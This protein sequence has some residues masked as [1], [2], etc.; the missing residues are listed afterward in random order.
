[1]AGTLARAGGGRSTVAISGTVPVAA[2]DAAPP[3]PLTVRALVLLLLARAPPLGAT[4]LGTAARWTARPSCRSEKAALDQADQKLDS[5]LRGLRGL[6]ARTARSATGPQA[7][8]AWRR[9]GRVRV[10][11]RVERPRRRDPRGADGRRALHRARGRRERAGRGLGAGRRGARGWRRSTGCGRSAPPSAVR[12]RRRSPARATSRRARTRCAPLG[13][14][15]SGRARRR[16]LRRRRRSRASHP[17]GELPATV[18]G[19]R[20]DARRQRGRRHRHA[21]DRARPRAR[22]DAAV[23]ER[24]RQPARASSRRSTCLTAAGAERDRRRPAASSASR[25]SRTGRSPQAVRAAV[26]R[27][28]SYHTAAGNSATSCTTRAMFRQSPQSKFHDFNTGGGVDNT[29]GVS[30]PPGGSLLCVLQWDDPFGRA[31]DDYDLLLLDENRDG[32]RRQQR[33][34]ERPRRS[35]SRSWTRTT[36]GAS[37]EVAYA[38]HRAR[39]AAMRA[40]SSCSALRDVQSMEHVTPGVEHLRPR[41]HPRGGHGRRHRR[42]RAWPRHG[43]ALQLAGARAASRSRRRSRPKPDLA[44]VRRR[45]HEVRASR[46]SSAR[47]RPRRTWPPSRR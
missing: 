32:D 40:R 1:M 4:S 2:S 37:T 46:R 22:R 28:V 3:L 17:T 42:R 31:S 33:R 21:R 36:T 38:R 34:A 35:A 25:T 41:R 15:G 7:S 9:D 20:R 43:R 10:L 26:R 8:R 13:F 14:D 6:A 45:E 23:R 5:R 30:I 47:R 39:S 27:G 44:G 19:A 16:D 12:P 11:V 18:L 24:H 29:N